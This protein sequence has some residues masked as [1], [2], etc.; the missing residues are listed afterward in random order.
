MMLDL[1]HIKLDSNQILDRFC[2]CYERG[3]I[4][5]LICYLILNYKNFQ[6]VQLIKVAT[7]TKTYKYITWFIKHF[8]NSIS[9]RFP[10]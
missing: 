9:E 3:S 8:F 1:I 6:T 4:M 10:L 2:F 7:T 5:I